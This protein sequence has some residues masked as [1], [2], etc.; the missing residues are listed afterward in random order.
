MAFLTSSYDVNTDLY[1]ISGLLIVYSHENL[2]NHKLLLVGRV[3][4]LNSTRLVIA[5]CA[6]M[7]LLVQE[8]T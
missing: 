4:E 8:L 3:H 1:C 2:P 7:A 5:V 6:H